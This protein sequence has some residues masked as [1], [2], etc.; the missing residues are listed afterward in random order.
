MVV[1]HLIHNLVL[2]SVANAAMPEI[3]TLK[4]LVEYQ[5]SAGGRFSFDSVL[6]SWKGSTPLSANRFSHSHH[7][8]VLP[9]L[10][11]S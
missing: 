10:V 11:T 1:D 8:C 7:Y 2:L 5:V 3:F 6:A 9:Y 4:L